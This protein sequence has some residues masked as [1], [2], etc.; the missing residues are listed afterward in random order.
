MRTF[1]I[2]N[3]SA[4]VND[5]NVALMVEACKIQLNQH[6]GP[7]LERVPWEIKVGGNDGFPVVLIDS[8]DVAG[9]LGYHTQ[10]PDGRV[11]C[12]VFTDPLLNNGGSILRGD[13]SVSVV[14]S[15]EI[16]ETFYNPYINLWS[17]RGDH[18]F[19]ALELCDPVQGD[20]YEID[21]AGTPVSVSNFVLEAWFDREMDRAGRFDY[22]NLVKKPLE[23]TKGGYTVIFNSETGEVASTFASKEGE[24]LHALLK[25][26][27]PASRSSRNKND[28]CV[29]K[30]LPT[31]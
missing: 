8:P 10:D 31:Y 12:R 13:H 24:E 29:T 15:H 25:P 23:M 16:L 20:S 28:C 19:V 18:T 14:L 5:E 9:A 30:N 27:H 2:I 11:W 26:H 1:N 21:V 3:R 17:N 4:K 6:A 7:L 22:M